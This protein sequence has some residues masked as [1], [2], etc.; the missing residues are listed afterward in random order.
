M[1]EFTDKASALHIT[2]AITPEAFLE[3]EDSSAAMFAFFTGV[4]SLMLAQGSTG[5]PSDV[6]FVP[7]FPNTETEEQD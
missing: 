4:E 6:S 7:Y 3:Y 5:T 1:N 2:I